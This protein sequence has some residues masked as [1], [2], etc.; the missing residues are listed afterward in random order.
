MGSHLH[1]ISCFPSFLCFFV[2]HPPLPPILPLLTPA[3]VSPSSDVLPGSAAS[4]HCQVT[5]K[6]EPQVEWLRPGG[7]VTGS[8]GRVQLSAVTLEDAGDWTCR[9]SKDRSEER[10]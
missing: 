6:P 2:F 1:V 10:L 8:A 7:G 9:I 5:G 4:L 3:S